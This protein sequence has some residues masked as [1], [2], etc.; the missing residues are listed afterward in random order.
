M[1]FVRFLGGVIAPY[2]AGRLAEA[3]DVHLPFYWGRSPSWLGSP[4]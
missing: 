1:G 4:C 3:F 2:V